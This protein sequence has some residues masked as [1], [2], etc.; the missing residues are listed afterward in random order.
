MSALLWSACASTS[1]LPNQAS[2]NTSSNSIDAIA[3]IS[4]SKKTSKLPL[5]LD[6]DE[7]LAIGYKIWKNECR[8]SIEGLTSWNKGEEFASLGIGHFIWFPAGCTA[9]FGEAFPQLVDA[10]MAHEQG[11]NYVPEWLKNAFARG[12]R[13]CPWQTREEFQAAQQSEEMR[14]LRTMLASTVSIQARYIANRLEASLPK[15][16]NAA[17]EEDRERIKSQFYRVATAP[18]G[19]YVLADYV[20]FK[21]EGIR[22]SEHY[23]HRGWGLLQ[24]L[25]G[26]NGKEEGKEALREFAA[27]A[28]ARLT[29]RI[30]NAP[31]ERN[32]HRWLPGWK[33]RIKTY[34]MK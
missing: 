10:L 8:G 18:M 14:E 5:V 26:M 9:P 24:V 29:E 23:R 30:E 34:C 20:N 7:A 22:T 3:K 4:P 21:G 12:E 31:P 32:E 25:Q 13:T 15:M 33:R 11:V 17:Q 1:S 27:S 28:E 19:L 16:L 2:T 6:D